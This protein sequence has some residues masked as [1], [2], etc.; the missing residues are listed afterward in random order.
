MLSL[1]DEAEAIL[2]TSSSS[3]R[4]VFAIDAVLADA[5]AG[6]IPFGLLWKMSQ[7]ELWH[8]VFVDEALQ[9]GAH[10]AVEGHD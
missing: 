1:R 10:W 7:V 5:R 4:G 3:K 8:Q 2:T 9:D 6:I